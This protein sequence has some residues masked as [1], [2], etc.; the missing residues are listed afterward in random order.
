MK[1][2]LKRRWKDT[3]FPQKDHHSIPLFCCE[4]T[5]A[6]CE[7]IV[8][9]QFVGSC[10]LQHGR[11]ITYDD[12]KIFI[13]P[14]YDQVKQNNICEHVCALNCTQELETAPNLNHALF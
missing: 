7:L 5:T 9:Q 1:T 14:F 3:Q 8:K 4:M 6:Y 2:R 13:Q 11:V 12:R 10:L